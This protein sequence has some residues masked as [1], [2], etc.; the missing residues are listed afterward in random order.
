M[1]KKILILGASIL[2]VPLIKEAKSMGLIVGIAD[3]NPNS[4]GIQYGDYFYQVDIFDEKE[5]YKIAKKFN[6]DGICT[7][8]TDYPMRSVA[9]CCEKLGLSSINYDTALNATDKYRMIEKFKEFGLP[10]PWY[11]VM[12]SLDKHSF[13]LE[14]INYPCIIK[15]IDSSGSRGVILVNDKKDLQKS[16]DYALLN[17]KSQKIIIE[18]F[19]IGEELSVEIFCSNGEP[20]VIQI[21]DKK[22]T[23]A[24]HFVELEHNEPAD[25]DTKDES[26][27]VNLAKSAVLSCGIDQGAA[28]VEIML[29]K[30]GPKLIELGA[31]L[32]G[33]FITTDLVPL[34]TG[35]NLVK[36]VLLH[37]LGEKTNLKKIYSKYSCV[38]FPVLPAG[39]IV[40]NI[41][42]HKYTDEIRYLKDFGFEVTEY[43]SSSDRPLAIISSSDS[44]KKLNEQ[45]K[46]IE[47]KIILEMGI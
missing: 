18:E 28:H 3:I 13:S 33:D 35:V 41:N 10:I 29:T 46:N 1:N 22:T 9:F 26:E 24:P 40:K 45:L 12:S 6:P 14:N 16:I 31:R 25:L 32:G 23:G 2:Q 30:D 7:I 19:L 43:S 36:N 37:S 15:P 17:S 42:S 20:Q 11:I 38:K 27:V 34:S 44:K 39:T 21:T 8:G 47:K 4:V 5:V